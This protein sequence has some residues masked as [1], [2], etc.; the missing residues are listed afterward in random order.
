MLAPRGSRWSTGQK[1]GRK[2]G[3][4]GEAGGRGGGDGGGGDGAVKIFCVRMGG[5]TLSTMTTWPSAAAK[6]AGE[7]E[8]VRNVPSSASALVASEAMM[9]AVTVTEAAATARETDDAGMARRV[10]RAA[11]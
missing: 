5:S 8:L 6:V 9:V 7:A 10:A 1:D 3:N 4:G 2:G 11:M